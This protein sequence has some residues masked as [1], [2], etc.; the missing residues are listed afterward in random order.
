MTGNPPFRPPLACGAVPVPRKRFRRLGRLLLSLLAAGLVT[1]VPAWGAGKPAAQP[2]TPAAVAAEEAKAYEKLG[3]LMQVL[4]L[5]RQ[6]YVDE[7]KTAFEPLVYDAIRGLVDGL[8]PFS[9]F[10][11]PEEFKSMLDLTEGKFGGLG[12]TVAEVNGQL[13]IIAPIEN[14][15]A[16]RAGIMPNDII[17]KIG[18][19]EVARIGYREAVSRLRGEPG[20]QVRLTLHRPSTDKTWEITL[21]RAVIDNPG[22]QGPFFLPGGVAYF[23]I[24]EFSET[25]PGRFR[26]AMAT[27]AMQK[28]PALILDLRDNPGGLLE[29]AVAVCS[30][31]LPPGKLVVFTQGRQPSQRKDFLT[32]HRN[33]RD[34]ER[35]LAI[36]V[37]GNSASAAEIVAGCL[38]DWGRAVLIGE[39]TFGKGSVQNLLDLADG[40]ALRL[41]TAKYYTPSKR[42]I[43][44][45]GIEPDIF[46]AGVDNDDTR[47]QAGNPTAVALNAG[48]APDPAL[49]PQL[50]RALE[51]LQSYTVFLKTR[52]RDFLAPRPA[53]PPAAAP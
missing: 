36:L 10:L 39:K 15:P 31:F 21:Q 27:A 7:D 12:I 35:P 51:T 1:A 42:V 50:A 44:G 43:H 23:H 52:D 2:A 48:K 14:S 30:Q 16:S 22:V 20:S 4:Y 29:S 18:S 53:P 3:V 46:V 34:I 32:D 13:A 19:V 40:S 38:Q 33:G 5:V 45:H 6:D 25:T 37:N 24:D 28:A 41:T 47:P 26:E 49:D 17:L 8:D 11:T 9:S